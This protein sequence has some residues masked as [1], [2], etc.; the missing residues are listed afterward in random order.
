MD[1]TLTLSPL[2][3]RRLS[4]ILDE[5]GERYAELLPTKVHPANEEEFREF[6]RLI[7]FLNTIGRV[8]GQLA[9]AEIGEEMYA[10]VTSER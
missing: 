6:N 9:R 8:G 10:L 3:A 2:D 4:G 1:I 5:A 7:K